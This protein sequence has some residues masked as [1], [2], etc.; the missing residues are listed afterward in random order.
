M[1]SSS[2]GTK[3]AIWCAGIFLDLGGGLS[4]GPCEILWGCKYC[5]WWSSWAVAVIGIPCNSDFGTSNKIG[6]NWGGRVVEVII[7]GRGMAAMRYVRGSKNLMVRRQGVVRTKN[8]SVWF[9]WRIAC[10][11]LRDL[12]VSPR[13]SWE[14]RSTGSAK[15]ANT[16]CVI[17]QK[18]AVLSYFWIIT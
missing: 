18:S 2:C 15:I 10:K 1:N 13:S 12:R 6:T 16:R 9:L 7:F 17:I 4:F 8:V 3:I 11:N 14:L 5:A